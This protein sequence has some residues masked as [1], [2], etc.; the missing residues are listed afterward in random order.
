MLHQVQERRQR[1]GGRC[2]CK[3][4]L[5][6]LQQTPTGGARECAAGHAVRHREIAW[7][8]RIDFALLANTTLMH[9][10][11]KQQRIFVVGFSGAALAESYIETTLTNGE[12][13]LYSAEVSIF[14]LVPSFLIGLILLFIYAPLGFLVWMV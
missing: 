13:V 12:N 2:R 10:A 11:I 7:L 4:G 5:Q 8:R 9:L 3:A 14:L 6:Q 1:C